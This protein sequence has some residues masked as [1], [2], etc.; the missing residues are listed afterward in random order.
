MRR[1][2]AAVRVISESEELAQGIADFFPNKST[3]MCVVKDLRTRYEETK[4]CSRNLKLDN[5]FT[6]GV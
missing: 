3:R 4:T 2:A 6:Q 5:A 1:D